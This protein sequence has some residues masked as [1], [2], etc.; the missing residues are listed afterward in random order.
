[1]LAA[2]EPVSSTKREEDLLAL[3]STVTPVKSRSSER[4]PTFFTFP[5]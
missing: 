3:V 5:S 2:V 1:M 4:T